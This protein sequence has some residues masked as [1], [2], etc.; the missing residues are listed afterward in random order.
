MT[1]IS[2][3]QVFGEGDD[4]VKV[5]PNLDVHTIEFVYE[6]YG[7]DDGGG[8]SISFQV[9]IN[10]KIASSVDSTLNTAIKQ[11]ASATYSLEV[12][13]PIDSLEIVLGK[14]TWIAPRSLSI[15]DVAGRRSFSVIEAAQTNPDRPTW[16]RPEW[17]VS[18]GDKLSYQSV[19]IA[20]SKITVDGGPGNDTLVLNDTTA[21]V[22]VTYLDGKVSLVTKTQGQIDATNFENYQFFDKSVSLREIQNNRPPTFANG[23]VEVQMAFSTTTRTFALKANDPDGDILSYSLSIT[24]QQGTAIISNGLLQY[25]PSKVGGTDTLQVAARDKFGATALQTYDIGPSFGKGGFVRIPGAQIDGQ[26]AGYNPRWVVGDFNGDG[27][28]DLSIRYDPEAAF[29][30]TVTGASPLRFFLGSVSGG[31]AESTTLLS[32]ALAPTLVNRIQ[33]ADLN[34]DGLPDILIGASGQDP[35]ENGKPAWDKYQGQMG[36]KSYILLSGQSGSYTLIDVPNMPLM[37]AHYLA[38][39]D[40]NNDG[41]V[42]AFVASLS[43]EPSYLLVSNQGTSFSVNRSLLPNSVTDSSFAVLNTFPGGEAKTGYSNQYSA[44]SIFDVDGDGWNDLVLLPIHNSGAGKVLFNDGKGSFANGRTISLPSGPYGF[45]FVEFLSTSG[46][47]NISSGTTYIDALSADVNGD[48]RLDLITVSNAAKNAWIEDYSYYRGSSISI[49]INTPNGFID[50]TSLR[51]DFKHDPEINYSHYDSIEYRDFN[52]DG[53]KDIIVYRSVGN[54]DGQFAT[55]ILI[56]DG[57]GKFSESRYPRELSDG[58]IIVV[59]EINSKY[60]LPTSVKTDR[61]L[62]NGFG[63]YSQTVDGLIFDWSKGLDLFT[64][65]P[66]G[67]G[68]VL[69]SD[70]PGRWVHGTAVDN[71]ITLSSGNEY[72]FGYQGNDTIDGGAGYDTAVYAEIFADVSIKLSGKSI[73]VSTKTEGVDTLTNIEA[74]RFADQTVTAASIKRDLTPS[75][76]NLVLDT[77]FAGSIGG[78]GRIVGTRGAQDITVSP[79][80]GSVSFDASFNAGGDVIRLPGAAADWT[81][82][83]TG[84]SARLVSDTLAATIPIGTNAN[85]IVFADGAR[86]LV[87]KDGSFKIGSQSFA[88]SAVKIT[89]VSDGNAPTLNITD[90][91]ARLVLS[92]GAE[93]SI[94]GKV[95]VMGTSSGKEYVEV[96]GGKV[97]FD[98]SFNGGGDVIDLPGNAKAWSAVRSGSSML[99]TKGS[100]SASIPIGTTGADLAFDDVTRTLL[101]ASGQFKIGTQVIE[102][103]FPI[104]LFG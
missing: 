50:E 104:T 40:V 5:K 13:G 26:D 83:R 70:I 100:D 59:D 18:K 74:L 9:L 52:A 30:T 31:F 16:A 1:D 77:G 75:S 10:G 96:L 43:K 99:L 19:G 51:S 97:S 79:R 60:A 17:L 33:T 72:A 22:S 101:F 85:W 57:T 44:A 6:T 55:R 34:K 102:G 76:F 66:D 84:S 93:A 25:T 49:L 38:V 29:S 48:G 39:G 3:S 24:P 91:T 41:Y 80:A 98:P 12:A 46:N 14:A 81:I 23:F 42:D 82:Q 63:N 58:L 64:G 86:T 78:S 32:P 45:G 37:F 11:W 27:I 2:G 73:I 36:E 94:G 47:S 88:E 62:A 15:T 8:R 20:G 92:S 61:I 95:L 65:Q 68:R 53:F 90:T 35:Y 103:S 87:Y 89:A 56:N 28:Q 71:I 4:A 67:R 7:G 21:D 69:S 54:V